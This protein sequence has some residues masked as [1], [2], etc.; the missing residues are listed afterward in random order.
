MPGR[1][2]SF[3]RHTA[4]VPPSEFMPAHNPDAEAEAA[5]AADFLSMGDNAPRFMP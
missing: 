5:S 3:G 1:V 2:P 4:A